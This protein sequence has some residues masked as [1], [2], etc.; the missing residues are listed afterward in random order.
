M[1]N[2]NELLGHTGYLISFSKSGYR[3]NHPDDIVAFNANV[4][5]GPLKVWWGDI[6]ITESKEK[7]MELAKLENEPV[8]VLSEMDAH[9]DNEDTPRI[10]N[11][12]VTFY[13]DGTYTTCKYITKPL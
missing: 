9:F 5:I 2:I 4:C 11:A 1:E 6:N 13:P 3:N 10:N 8:H 7:L 12:L